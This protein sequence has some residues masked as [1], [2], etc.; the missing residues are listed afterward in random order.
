MLTRLLRLGG[1]LPSEEEDEFGEEDREREESTRPLRF[2]FG[3]ASEEE[4]ESGEGDEDREDSS[5]GEESRFWTGFGGIWGII[6][7]KLS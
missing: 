4:D 7:P 5:L 1:G 3:L 2:G 6:C